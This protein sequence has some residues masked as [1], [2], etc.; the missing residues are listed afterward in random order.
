LQ[1]VS[2]PAA[3]VKVKIILPRYSRLGQY[4]VAV[5][6]QRSRNRQWRPGRVLR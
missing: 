2:L 3:L 5:T 1:S 4:T 6:R